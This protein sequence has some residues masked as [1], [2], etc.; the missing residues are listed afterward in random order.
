MSLDFTTLRR[1][2]ESP[3]QKIYRGDVLGEG[4]FAAVFRRPGEDLGQ[5]VA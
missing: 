3:R 4:G 5:D 2:S 1:A